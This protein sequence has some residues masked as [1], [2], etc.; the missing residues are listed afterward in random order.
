M[1]DEHLAQL[2]EQLKWLT[3]AVVNNT[4]KQVEI[5]CVDKMK[6]Q[7]TPGEKEIIHRDCLEEVAE[8][9]RLIA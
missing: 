3:A 8:I 1:N 2:V 5:S 9:R 4:V 7:L 6:R